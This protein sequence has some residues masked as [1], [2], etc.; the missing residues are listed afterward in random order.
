MISQR[1]CRKCHFISNAPK[2]PL[3][4]NETS[5]EWQGYLVVMEPDK[6]E[7]AKKMGIKVKG[8]YALRV[9]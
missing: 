3:C 6:S 2:C 7:I 5:R 9:K 1:A 4:S 8:S